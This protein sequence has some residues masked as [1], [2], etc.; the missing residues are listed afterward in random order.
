MGQLKIQSQKHFNWTLG[1]HKYLLCSQAVIFWQIFTICILELTGL[2]YTKDFL[3]LKWP[4]ISFIFE[5]PEIQIAR[6][7]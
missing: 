2:T 4:K 5:K 7:L 3:I 6:F 1:R